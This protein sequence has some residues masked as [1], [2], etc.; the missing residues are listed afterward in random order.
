MKETRHSDVLEP[1]FV[2]EY[3]PFAL[4]MGMSFLSWLSGSIA[5]E[6][7]ITS[8]RN[9]GLGF[10]FGLIF[11]ASLAAAL[12][13]WN[14]IV[15]SSRIGL[16]LDEKGLTYTKAG[17][18]GCR[19]LGIP[20]ESISTITE[21]KG[22]LIVESGQGASPVKISTSG[23]L[24][25]PEWILERCNAWLSATAAKDDHLAAGK[26]LAELSVRLEGVV[27]RTCGG[28]VEVPTGT[29]EAAVCRFCG[30]SRG[31]SDKVKES[32]AR[33]SS[34]IRDLPA[35]HRQFQKDTLRRFMEDGGKHRR[36]LLG[37]GWGTAGVWLL[38]AA[39]NVISELAR[40]EVKTIDYQ[41]LGVTVGL[42]VISVAT[43][44]LLIYFLRKVSGKFSLPMLALAPVEAGGTAR[45]RLCG[46]ELPGTGVVRRCQYC[47]SDS[48]VSGLQLA[49]AERKAQEAV[50]RAQAAV[51]R[52]TES[53]GRLLDGVAVKMQYFA[54]GQFFWLHIPV[55][56]ALDG[57]TGML[58]RLTGI[59][60]AMLVGNIASA[61]LG[62][63]WLKKE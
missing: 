46:A 28:S 33:L 58:F 6:S 60:L 63:K 18:L 20:W 30:D 36:T 3:P 43:S 11:L 37:V 25:N 57:S 10:L 13:S 24:E 15:N 34:I 41:F 12:F 26:A 4:A 52:S 42:A 44:Y 32:L 50:A 8:D 16:K 62:M 17:L 29:A 47:N 27:C 35:A 54:N 14:S 1:V 51:N 48:V 59:C 2:R 21:E 38:F 61:V 56:V 19:V 9:I 23:L 5:Y 31:L 22:V 7:L 53:A 49:E 40:E 55:L 39:V 45:C